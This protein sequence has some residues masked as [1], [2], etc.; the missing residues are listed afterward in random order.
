MGRIVCAKT[1][2]F[3]LNVFDTPYLRFYTPYHPR[4]G[5]RR[6]WNSKPCHTATSA[7]RKAFAAM[8]SHVLAQASCVGAHTL[9][10]T[11]EA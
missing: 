8:E 2:C 4:M 1:S 7:G 9:N 6:T 5:G 10:P 11:V 3:N